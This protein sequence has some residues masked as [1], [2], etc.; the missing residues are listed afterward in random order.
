VIAI[1][2]GHGGSNLGAAGTII[3]VSDRT[4]FEKEI[5]LALARRLRSQLGARGE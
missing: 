2:A 1:D 3:E 5:T 4:I